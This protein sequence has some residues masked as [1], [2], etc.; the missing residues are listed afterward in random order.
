MRTTAKGFYTKLALVV[1]VTMT[2]GGCGIFGGKKDENID[3]LGSRTTAIGVNGYLWQATLDTLS[4]MPMA[5]MDPASGAITTEWY[6]DPNVTN[7]RLKVMVQ[8]FGEG[9]R[10]DGVQVTV[11]RQVKLDNDWVTAAVKAATTLEIEEAILT[12]AR[13]LRIGTNS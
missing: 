8:F 6:T 1:A 13:Q 2:L 9:L 11:N 7:E 12:R 3:E 5:Q 4:F 10:A